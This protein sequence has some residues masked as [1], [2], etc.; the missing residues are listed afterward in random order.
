MNDNERS[1]FCSLALFV[2]TKFDFIDAACIRFVDFFRQKKKH[3]F[4]EHLENV[5]LSLKWI[6]SPSPA[7][8]SF[9]DYAFLKFFPIYLFL[10]LFVVL[11]HLHSNRHAELITAK[12]R[13]I[14]VTLLL[15]SLFTQC[16]VYICKIVT[17]LLLGNSKSRTKMI[18]S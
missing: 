7:R 16:S 18:Q 12:Q 13:S 9:I 4:R 5:W 3:V 15:N 11:Y 1:R 14:V 6:T 17:K 2:L 10:F 8:Q